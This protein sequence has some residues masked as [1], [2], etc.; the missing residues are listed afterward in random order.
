MSMFSDEGLPSKTCKSPKQSGGYPEGIENIQQANEN[1][2]RRRET[3]LRKNEMKLRKNDF[4]V[5]KNL[6][7]PPWRIGNSYRGILR[8]P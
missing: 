6:F 5:P 3:K 2:P 1:P 4:E 7:V 8:F